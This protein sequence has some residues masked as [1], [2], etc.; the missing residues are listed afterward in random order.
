MIKI[1]RYTDVDASSRGDSCQ[2]ELPGE[3]TATEP[4]PFHIGPG[5][6]LDIVVPALPEMQSYS[7]RVSSDGSLALPLLGIV[8]AEGLTEPQLAESL[9]K[10]LTRYMY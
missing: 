9:R 8:P 4:D 2:E 10:R 1:L 5:D 3:R 7:A 6:T